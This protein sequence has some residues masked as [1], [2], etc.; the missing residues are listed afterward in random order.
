MSLTKLA[1]G[2]HLAGGPGDTTGTLRR[3]M[4]FVRPYR[5]RLGTYALLL[6]ASAAAGM[7]PPLIFRE[8]LDAAIPR[9]DVP[10]VNLLVGLAILAY[11][12][13][14][15]MLL[16][17]GYLGTLIGT[18]IIRDLR[19]VLFD[20]L[21]RLPLSFFVHAK[22]GAVQSR[23]NTD[24]LNAQQM[25]TGHL[26]TGSVG[27]I[28][29]DVLI[30]AFT[31][32]AMVVLSWQVTLAA[33]VLMP[34][35]LVASRRIGPRMRSL[36]REQMDLFGGMNA[37]AA[38]R[39]NVGGALLIKLFG[40]YDRESARF[41]ARTAALRR[42]NIRVNMLALLVGTGVALVGFLGVAAVYWSGSLLAVSGP[43]T[44]GTVV[45][46]A[47]YAQR[48]Y[49]P[50]MDLASARMNLQSAL[51]SFERVFEVVDAPLEI[52]ERPHVGN[53]PDVV[54]GAVEIDGLWF[55]HAGR[56]AILVQSLVSEEPEAPASGARAVEPE[57]WALRDVSIGLSAGTMTALVGPS[58][59]GAHVRG[60]S[61]ALRLRPKRDQMLRLRRQAS[62]AVRQRGAPERRTG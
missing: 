38:E 28:A 18:D 39:L 8:L 16:L 30:I 20:H 25:F 6:A 31:L 40:G 21:Q 57:S 42:N 14:A 41:A 3:V 19:Q 27:S 53:G 50:L 15:G 61:G 54:Q 23:L 44:I 13:S 62:D 7:I 26:Y 37:F 60:C 33:L 47:A 46:L 5:W 52:T 43:L 59:P 51:V 49:A 36:V 22:T 29:A 11:L 32:G 10:L 34:L 12:A 24:V 9:R 35:F 55:R 17:G 58:D 56:R 4:R 45:A 1:S 48:A 2:Y